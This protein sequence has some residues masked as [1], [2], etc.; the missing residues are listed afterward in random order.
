MGGP[1]MRNRGAALRAVGA[2]RLGFRAVADWIVSSARSRRAK[3]SSAP[4]EYV[5][6]TDLMCALG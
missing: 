3:Q 5:D 2:D 4:A 6:E 1:W